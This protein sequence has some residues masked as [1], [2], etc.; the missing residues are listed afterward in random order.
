MIFSISLTDP[1][2]TLLALVSVPRKLVGGMGIQG[3][4]REVIRVVERWLGGGSGL[5]RT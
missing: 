1:S 5:D 3:G 2:M 4:L